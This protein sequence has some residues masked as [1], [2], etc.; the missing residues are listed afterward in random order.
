LFERGG[1][2][3]HVRS[4]KRSLEAFQANAQKIGPAAAGGYSLI[5]SVLLLGALGY[6]LD[7]WLG[8]GPW[9]LVGGLLFGFAAG[10][11]L[12]GK[13]MFKR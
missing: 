5:G 10:M 2:K 6:G 3:G 12:L 9:L 13:E 11:Y 8:T 1:K 7:R 4:L